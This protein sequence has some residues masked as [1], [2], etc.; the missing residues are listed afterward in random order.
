MLKRGG[1]NVREEGENKSAEEYIE[2]I[3]ELKNENTEEKRKVEI[4]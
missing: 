4:F 3:E 1:W 2:E